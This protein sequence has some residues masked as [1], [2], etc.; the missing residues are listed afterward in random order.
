MYFVVVLSRFDMKCDPNAIIHLKSI[1]WK[2]SCC[3][4]CCRC[5]CRH[6]IASTSLNMFWQEARLPIIIA[7]CYFVYILLYTISFK[8][9]SLTFFSDLSPLDI[10]K[11]QPTTLIV[12]L[13]LPIFSILLSFSHSRSQSFYLFIANGKRFSAINQSY[14][15]LRAELTD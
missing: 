3:R 2:R 10:K 7:Y 1:K 4:R 9:R 11:Q 13:K 6:R 15:C 12:K 8:C 5:S 14:I